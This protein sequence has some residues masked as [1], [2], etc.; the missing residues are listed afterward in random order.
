M[1]S[2]GAAL[3]CD[4][5]PFDHIVYSYA[6]DND[7]VDAVA[8]FASAGLVKIEASSSWLLPNTPT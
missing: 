8:L 6:E 7:L 3:L 4:P 1:N 5:R 2:T